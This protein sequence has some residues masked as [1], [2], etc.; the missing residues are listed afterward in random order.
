MR[1]LLALCALALVHAAAPAAECPPAADV[2]QLTRGSAEE[3]TR[4]AV[5]RGFLWQLERGGRT[6]WL[7]GTM[8]LG[9]AE[10]LIPGPTVR[11]ALAQ[12]DTV[13]LE[14]DLGDPATLAVFAAPADAA[15]MA[16]VLTP[17]RRQRLAQQ[18][19]LACLP[20]GALAGMRPILQLATL[21]MLAARSE[22][23]YADFGSEAFLTMFARARKKPLVGLESAA[24]QLKA[25][26]GETE[27]EEGEQIDQG[28]TD[29]ESG[30]ARRQGEQ[31][32]DVWAHSDWTR[33]DRYRQWCDCIRTPADELALRRLL[34]DRNPGLAA[35]IARLHDGGQ[36]VFAAVGALHMVGSAG[37]PALLESR[38]FRV[39]QRVPA[40]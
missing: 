8:H 29:L 15:V 13:A 26:A 2:G 23:L 5:D 25:L 14:L 31:L 33:L 28:L 34:D 21:S 16:R 27:A 20:D 35:G 17:E 19:A 40:P 22:G 32:A 39:T 1:R 18:A 37:L 6:S 38:G 11:E 24:D 4:R 7:Y 30:D 36:R 9:K 10:W 3:A 12:S